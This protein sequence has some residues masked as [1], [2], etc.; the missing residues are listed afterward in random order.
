MRR[1][2]LILFVIA[3]SYGH[4]SAQVRGDNMVH[5]YLDAD[6]RSGNY[7]RDATSIPFTANYPDA[8]NPVEGKLKFS[9]ASTF[10][11]DIQL[12]YYFSRKNH[13]GI[14]AGIMYLRQQG[15]LSL[16]TFHVEYSSRD[17]KGN[18]YRQVISSRRGIHEAITSSNLSIPVLLRYKLKASKLISLTFDGG[19][20][21][22][23]P[24]QNDYNAASK[25]DY[26]A[27]YKIG[28][29]GTNL[30]FTYDNGTVP[31]Q[32]DWLITKNEFAKDNPKGNMQDYFTSLRAV[33]YNVGINQAVNT[34][35]HVDY[36]AKT[37]GYM[38]QA[39]IDIQLNKVM[40]AKV[41][42]YYL[43]QS[44]KNTSNTDNLQLTGQP[45]DYNSLLNYNRTIVNE[46]Y[47]FSLG[48]M[49]VIFSY[50]DMEYPRVP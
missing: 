41:G 32:R 10:G 5:Y 36:R 7:N 38:F 45:G 18:A 20:L 14:E 8:V 23:I 2:L 28:G 34:S 47:G 9:D 11:Y 43:S 6:I 39:A 49:F 50:H 21:V 42:G 29:T 33:G 17:Y 48:L 31:D 30:S 37:V 4:V 27:I 22:G 46:S 40:M 19:I 24:L 3:A 35:G 12:G 44:F 16:D 13:F 15:N 25:F 26:E 1:F